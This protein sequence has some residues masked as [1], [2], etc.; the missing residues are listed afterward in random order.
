MNDRCLNP[1]ELADFPA[2]DPRWSHVDD[3]PRCQAVMKSF[4]AFMDPAD[5]PEGADLADA[6][7]RLSAA[8]DREI[9]S[10]SS[11][12]PGK[13]KGPEAQVIRPATS[14]WNPF[15][16]R[17]LAAAAA[18][19]IVAVGLSVTRYGPET[20]P[21]EPVLRAAGDVAAPFRCE[22]TGL[23]NGGYLLSWPE[24]EEAT[25]YRVVV[26]RAD[27]EELMDYDVGDTTSLELELP[28]DG[29]FC[30]VIALRDGDEVKR[31]EPAYFAG[32]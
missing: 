28:E 19:V 24:V 18:V 15:R 32:S 6:H 16:V 9:G 7:A 17:A 27:L 29:A 5:V 3:C 11:V 21:R 2:E 20:P 1:E 4:A 22:I 30:R 8:L 12:D 31:S 14:F 10:G 13:P 25:S 26:Y 23:E